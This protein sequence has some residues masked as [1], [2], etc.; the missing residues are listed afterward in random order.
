MT[1]AYRFFPDD[2]VIRDDADSFAIREFV[3]DED[4]R[5]YTQ[6][7]L[8]YNSQLGEKHRFVME[9]SAIDLI[10]LEPNQLF[11]QIDG[12]GQEVSN[13]CLGNI[14]VDQHLRSV[15]WV[16]E[17]RFLFP[18]VPNPQNETIEQV[19]ADLDSL[20]R[21]SPLSLWNPGITNFPSALKFD[22]AINCSNQDFVSYKVVNE[23]YTTWEY[24]GRKATRGRLSSEIKLFRDGQLIET[25]FRRHSSV[26]ARI[27]DGCPPDTCA[28]DC[29]A[30]TCC[31]GSDGIAVSS[32]AKSGG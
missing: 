2:E 11:D 12:Q 4:A 7:F 28:V 17:G 19:R 21:Y 32:F 1:V 31:Y 13:L 14:G 24:V 9:D 23:I 25:L 3:L 22:L 18:A 10:S 30:V 6:V 27:I 26:S 29:G 16:A 20:S 8:L 5:G 15:R